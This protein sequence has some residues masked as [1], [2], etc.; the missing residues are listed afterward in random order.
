M[1][2][3]VCQ[4][5][6]VLKAAAG[7]CVLA[8]V[9]A[10]SC[11]LADDGQRL[12]QQ[13]CAS[14]HGAKNEGVI[15]RFE[16]PITGPTSLEELASYVEQSMP[17]DEPGLIVGDEARLIAEFVLKNFLGTEVSAAVPRIELVHLTVE[18]HENSV[19]DILAGFVGKSAVIK[20]G[21]LSGEYFAEK[22]F[23]NGK[24][25]LSRID[26]TVR[27]D[28]GSSS[29][30]PEQPHGKE[31]S[32]I[33]RGS[34]FA[35]ESGE[36]SFRVRSAN[37][38]KLHVNDDDV[39]IIDNWVSTPE[40]PEKSATIKLLGGRWYRFTLATF[41]LND[42]AFA[43][44]LFWQ[45]PGRIE[46]RIQSEYLSP[47][48]SPK[49]FVVSTRFSADDSS[50]GYPRGTIVSREWDQA[51]TFVG[52]EVAEMILANPKQLVGSNPAE[53]DF[54]RKCQRF[55]RALAEAAFRRG[56]TEDERQRYVDHF[57]ET[58]ESP[59][60]A[61]KRSVLSIFKSPAFLF[62]EIQSADD[63]QRTIANRLALFLND[64]IPDRELVEQLKKSSSVNE[65]SSIEMASCLAES[66]PGKAKL[67]QFFRSW[68]KIDEAHGLTRDPEQFGGFDERLVD[69]LQESLMRLVEEVVWNDASD[70]RQ[71]FLADH[72]WMSPAMKEF[73]A[74]SADDDSPPPEVVQERSF[75]RI[76]SEN[77]QRAG[78]LTHPLILSHLAYYRTT[79]PI[80]RGV[81][82]TRGL[83]GIGLKPPPI[84][85]EPLGEDFDPE[86][87][88]RQRV[89]FQTRPAN[90]MA[91]HEVINP[92]GFA[93]ENI[94][95]VG[96]FRE[97]DNQKPVNAAV[98]FKTPSGN[99]LELNGPRQLAEY[100]V[101]E[102]AAHRHFVESLFHHIVKQPVAAYGEKRLDELTDGFVASEFNI[103]KLYVDIAVMAA[104][105][106]LTDEKIEKE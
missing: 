7:Y 71:L 32:V 68:L 2:L 79:S 39:P 3:S 19:A 41:K 82:V 28:C 5:T 36:Y 92:L 52:I 55:C 42:P 105:F 54:A 11:L 93:F 86:M 57:F 64:S 83:L 17:A 81:F 104:R 18:Q 84:A 14:C 37:G 69:D 90:C 75:E 33:W 60:V 16:H 23:W 102:Q 8:F 106:G 88:T 10:S 99:L 21:G 70:Y 38:F 12:Y 53:D 76:D 61:L 34:L 1:R 96:R 103:R 29:P 6:P 30:V 43:I 100:L 22:E 80:H 87:T 15:D 95:A 72:L 26:Q 85:V 44:D 47:E 91:C 35:P 48:W 50:V 66:E 31:F 67:R 89:E 49:V 27:I 46:S 73:Y 101:T 4:F 63:G 59:Q 58:A 97:T 40:E 56:I 24:P 77:G 78:L 62:P 45:R 13:H 98:Q 51:T 74:T 65:E 9:V 94:D 20:T 25:V